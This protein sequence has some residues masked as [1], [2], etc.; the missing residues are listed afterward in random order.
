MGTILN[1]PWIRAIKLFER[2]KYAHNKTKSS[3]SHFYRF[4]HWGSSFAF[5]MNSP[6]L[7]T[8]RV[9][10]GS[11]VCQTIARFLLSQEFTVLYS[12]KKKYHNNNKKQ[13]LAF[14]NKPKKV[15][16]RVGNGS[17]FFHFVSSSVH[18]IFV[19]VFSVYS[20]YIFLCTLSSSH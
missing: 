2:R 4:E 8:V 14:R 16:L 15:F 6:D 17:L 13:T 5:F 3:R 11:S 10:D 19:C 20:S 7:S 9:F 18:S 1:M 12:N